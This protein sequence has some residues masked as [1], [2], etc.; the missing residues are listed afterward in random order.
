MPVLVL[1]ESKLRACVGFD[2]ESLRTIEDAF[3]WLSEGKVEM[4]PVMHIEVPEH[5]GDVDIKS[6]CVRGL[7]HLAVKVAS[8]FFDNPKLGLPSGGAMVVVLNAK[9][10]FCEAV[11]LDNAYLTDLRT[12]LAGAVAARYLAPETVRTVGV[13]GSGAQAR[14][15]IRALGL[16]RDFERVLVSARDAGRTAAYAAQMSESLGLPVEATTPEALVRESELVITTTPARSPIVD[17]A[18]LHPGLHITAM[19]ADLPGKQELDPEVLRSAG[20]VVCD[21]REQCLAMGELQHAAELLDGGNPPHRARRAYCGACAGP[22]VGGGEHG[23]RSHGDRGSGHR[24]RQPRPHARPRPRRRHRDR[25][26]IRLRPGQGPR[27]KPMAYRWAGRPNRAVSERFQG[28]FEAAGAR[29]VDGIAILR[30]VRWKKSAVEM[31]C[32]TRQRVSQWRGTNARARSFA[33]G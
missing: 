17:A 1:T 4:P 5:H 12:G 32:R 27:E 16:V 33:R 3:T 6:A 23:L 31:T 18:W 15:Q 9:T 14:Y 30:E 26:L 2:A 13:L 21:R 11:M 8:G 24:N 28:A 7:D 10:G 29:V 25:Q 19:G 20:R 22:A